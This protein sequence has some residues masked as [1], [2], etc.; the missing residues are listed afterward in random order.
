MKFAEVTGQDHLKN[1]LRQGVRAGRI[2]HAQLFLGGQGS[3]SLGLALAY[4]TYIGCTARTEEDSCGECPSCRKMASLTH[5]D[6]HFSFPF[7][8]NKGDM[9]TE[10]YAEWREALI[11][12]PLMTYE[13]WMTALGAENKQ[14][15]IPIKECH[16]IIRNLSLKAYE[17]EYKMLLMWL[18]EYLGHE[19]NVLLKIMEEPPQKTLFLLVAENPD[20][21]LTTIRSRTQLVR[22]PPVEEQAVAEWLKTTF[23]TPD[24]DARRLALMSGGNLVLAKELAGN[25]ENQY[26]TP[27]RKWMGMCY[28]KKFNEAMK[29][30]EDFSGQGREQMKG[31]FTYALEIIRAVIANKYLGERSGLSPQEQKF[32]EQFGALLDLNKVNRMYD[33]FSK[34]FYE[35]ERNGNARMILSDLSFGMGKILK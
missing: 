17:N 26:L 20:K 10:L 12:N 7:P 8:S 21:I 27:F 32:V 30:A 5:P 22:V 33:M 15:N 18:P 16:A 24:E 6:L 13:D 23:S 25:E 31:F 9:A 14:G 19:G 4:A 2:P 29:W 35:T 28:H 11:A 34:A 3:G 1:I